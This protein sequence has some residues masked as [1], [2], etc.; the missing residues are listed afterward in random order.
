MY[1]LADHDKRR[2]PSSV[3]HVFWDSRALI[4]AK[5]RPDCQSLPGPELLGVSSAVRAN[6]DVQLP[7]V[8]LLFNY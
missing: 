2:S 7:L 3:V 5:S 8:S 6:M 4:L 1:E